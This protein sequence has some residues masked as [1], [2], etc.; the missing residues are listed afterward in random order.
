MLFGWP[1][2]VITAKIT[3]TPKELPKAWIGIKTQVL[4]PDVAAALKIPGAKGFR[5]TEVYALHVL[6]VTLLGW[7]VLVKK[8]RFVY[9]TPVVALDVAHHLVLPCLTLLL[10]TTAGG[11]EDQCGWLQD[12]YGL[13]WQIIPTALGRM[14]GDKDAKKATAAMKAMLQMKKLDIKDLQQAHDQG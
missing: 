9:L 11:R 2:L 8:G 12:K 14:L 4:V 3:D 13:S 5:I 1:S 6:L 10:V 7:V